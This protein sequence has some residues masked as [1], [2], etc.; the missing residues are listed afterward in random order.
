MAKSL[1]RFKQ[2]TINQEG[3]YMKVGT[4]GVLLG[5][6]CKSNNAKTILDIGTGT[7]LLSLMLA[8]RN[9]YAIID[10]VEIEPQAAKQAQENFDNSS[11]SSR[12]RLFNCS[13]QDYKQITDI[14]YDL[15][16]CNPPFFVN[17][18]KADSI[19]RTL[20]R[21]TDELT[22][23]E[24]S[25]A[26]NELLNNEGLFSVIL[27]SETENEMRDLMYRYGFS[28]V[29]KVNVIP[30]PGKLPK[31]V[32]LEFSKI[33]NECE[34]SELIIEEF[35]RHKYSEAYKTLTRDFYLSI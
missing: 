20:A 11:W 29:R 21:H 4:D 24:L 30:V 18:M 8:Q 34:F 2:F 26:V 25:D 9:S 32:L 10:A 12:L 27:P 22:F 1:F 28:L 6:W 5:A 3:A 31:R 19:E 13:V 14:K 23:K 35:G 7:G 17:S 15:I 16:V 33:Y